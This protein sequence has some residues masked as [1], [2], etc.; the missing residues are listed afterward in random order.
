MSNATKA[1]SYGYNEGGLRREKTVTENGSTVTHQYIYAG[2]SLS[3]DITAGYKLYFHYGADGTPLGFTY[4]A[5]ESTAVYSYVR[6]LQ[7]D[8]VG[9]VDASGAVVAEYSYD[10]WGKVLSSSGSMAE[11]NPLRY[12]GYYY[13]GETGFYYVSS[14]YYD[15]EIGRWI[16]ADGF[17]ST[18]QD[19]LG[20]NM[21][22]YC[23]NN[24][25]NRKD[26]TGQ[27]W[28]TALIVTAVVAVCTVTLSGCSAKP[29]PAPLP[30]KTADEAAMA[31]ANSTYS[32]SSYIRHEYGTVIYSSTTNGTTTYDFATPVAG[33]PH[34]VGY[35]N[36]KIPSGTTK[37]ATAHTHPNSNNFSGLTPGATSGDIP[38][39][40]RRGLDSYVI[41]PN[42]NLQKYSISSGTVSVVGVAS[43]VALTSQQQAA[44]VSQFQISWDNHL[45]TC[46]FGCEHMTWPTP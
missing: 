12:R 37:V 29:D 46:A 2:S 5:G 23:G 26:P 14:R 6:S 22:A 7:G 43:P 19:I 39:A 41:G 11:I 33:S 13:D 36:V 8:I 28:I 16:N 20:Y 34:S 9:I 32:S 40:I 27:F 10:G 45:G 25:I 18:G 44:L 21:F 24:P 42:L 35:G 3:A 17:V 15:P 4:T 1:V 38:N 30:Y 31:F